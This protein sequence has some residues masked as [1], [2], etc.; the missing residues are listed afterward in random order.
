MV[1]MMLLPV[2]IVC[3]W[4]NLKDGQLI[5]SRSGLCLL[6]FFVISTVSV[7]MNRDTLEDY[8]LMFFGGVNLNNLHATVFRLAYFPNRGSGCLLHRSIYPNDRSTHQAACMD[9]GHFR[10]CVDR[11]RAYVS[12]H[13]PLP[14]VVPGAAASSDEGLRRVGLNHVLCAHDFPD[15]SFDALVVEHPRRP[16]KKT[17]PLAVHRIDR[18]FDRLV[19]AGSRALCWAWFSVGRS[20]SYPFHKSRAPKA[21]FKQLLYGIVSLVIFLS[22]IVGFSFLAAATAI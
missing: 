16:G 3:L 14:V 17:A 1:W 5:I 18:V 7:L 11:G 4:C 2:G 10:N 21:N 13:R 12:V 22:I 15:L 8:A 9:Y 20:V 19:F 6:L